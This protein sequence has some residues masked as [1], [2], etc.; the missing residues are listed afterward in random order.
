MTTIYVLL[1]LLALA[2]SVV[3]FGNLL[4]S[5][6]GHPLTTAIGVWI[7]P[8]SLFGGTLFLCLSIFFWKSRRRQELGLLRRNARLLTKKVL[9]LC[10][11]ITAGTIAFILLTLVMVVLPIQEDL[12]SWTPYALCVLFALIAAYL[13][14]IV[15]RGLIRITFN[16]SVH[17]IADKS[18]SR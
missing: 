13:A 4:V 11:S 14:V 2:L 12:P 1:A 16:E 8:A 18:G 5:C 9:V 6:S 17:R 3:C 7:I 15:Y 10:A